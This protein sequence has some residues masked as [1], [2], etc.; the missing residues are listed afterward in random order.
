MAEE[1]GELF[2]CVGLF[3]CFAETL[4]PLEGETK[5]ARTTFLLGVEEG[6]VTP[7]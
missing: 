7:W 4:T 6:E 3:P 2:P 5:S 1:W